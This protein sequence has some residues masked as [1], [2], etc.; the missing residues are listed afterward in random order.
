MHETSLASIRIKI[1]KRRFLP[2]GHILTWKAASEFGQDNNAALAA[3]KERA[4]MDL[5]EMFNRS[6]RYIHQRQMRSDYPICRRTAI[7]HTST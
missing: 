6:I 7:T 2:L 4:E 1:S 3:Q 5:K